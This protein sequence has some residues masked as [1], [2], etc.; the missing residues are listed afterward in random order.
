MIKILHGFGVWVQTMA[1]NILVETP[2]FGDIALGPLQ[3][4]DAIGHRGE[5]R[6]NRKRVL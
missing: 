1:A 5:G 2:K 3:L 6:K 4:R